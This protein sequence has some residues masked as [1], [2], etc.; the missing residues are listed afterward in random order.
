MADPGL[1]STA[2]RDRLLATIARDRLRDFTREAWP[3]V[4]PGHRLIWGWHL[5]AICE[6]LEAVTRGEI[7]RLLM[8][9]PPRHMKSLAT[10]V[11]WPAWEWLSYPEHRFL[12]VSHSGPL[13]IRDAHKTRRL[14]QSEGLG[15]ADADLEV[16]NQG[17][18]ATLL[19]RVGYQGL[20]ALID[21]RWEFSGDQ[22]LKSRYENDRTGYRIST[23]IGG[24]A[25][26]EG[27]DR[28]MI[29]DPHKLE[30]WDS[31]AN[32]A[33]AVEFVTEVAPSRLNSRD[34][35]IVMI[36][37]RI[38]EKDATAAVLGEVED[39][40]GWGEVVHLCLPEQ[41]EPAHPF[42]Y[43]ATVKLPDRQVEDEETGELEM[44]T[45]AELQGDPRTAPGELLWEGRFG[46][47][48]VE[49]HKRIGSLR[50]A[51]NYQQRPAPA[52]GNIFKK[53]DWRFYGPGGDRSDL[54]PTWQKVQYHWD[55]TFGESDDPGAS[56][57]V[58]QC[59]ALDGPDAYLL[60]QVRKRMSFPDQKAAVPTLREF[61]PLDQQEMRGMVYVEEKAAGRPLLE[62]LRQVE[63]GLQGRNPEQSKVARAVSVQGYQ[64]AHNI[65]LPR[66]VIPAPPG[67]E[68]TP[69]ETFIHEAAT[70][71]AGTTDQVDVM[72]QAL[73][74]LYR[75]RTDEAVSVP[76]GP[77]RGEPVIEK[78]GKRFVGEKYVDRE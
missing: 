62:E 27:G 44:L 25:T 63:P 7:L 42:V 51:G 53:A 10:S 61:G 12:S 34:A 19:Q 9:V 24:G 1:L 40:P 56:W 57:V 41:Y 18:P 75:A 36:M 76:T 11:F 33:D 22:N 68:P 59:W 67:F 48:E 70:F 78:G 6:H 74:E 20:L 23:S 66:G 32:L 43:P 30:E 58:G 13:A 5:D 77:A 46:E 71:P 47:E 15:L 38:H 37:Q 8:N 49:D 28:I 14:M 45:G 31:E 73:K 52:E 72:S 29:D 39:K 16:F 64:E 3:L 21:N 50:Y 60:A 54:P 35:A 17:E 55:L 2:E 26:G 69:T 65:W 4:E